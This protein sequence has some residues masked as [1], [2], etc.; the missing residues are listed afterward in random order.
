MWRRHPPRRIRGSWADAHDAGLF[1]CGVAGPAPRRGQRS[2]HPH[3]RAS[4]RLPPTGTAAPIAGA[5]GSVTC[6]DRCSIR[7]PARW[8][9]RVPRTG[10]PHAVRPFPGDPAATARACGGRCRYIAE[11][12]AGRCAALPSP[13]PSPASPR[14]RHGTR[15]HRCPAQPTSGPVRSRPENRG[16]F[17]PRSGGPA[18]ATGGYEQARALAR[19]GWRRARTTLLCAQILSLICSGESRA[20]SASPRI[21]RR[22]TVATETL[23]R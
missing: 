21:S 11:E 15:R 2:R 14:R 7:S 3:R 17:R 23:C 16:R 13:Y 8:R 6:G 18:P 1:T 12:P 19:F 20:V 4:G 9:R 22:E 5:P 10:G